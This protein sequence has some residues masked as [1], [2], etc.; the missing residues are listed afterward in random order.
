MSIQ[1]IRLSKARRRLNRRQ[2]RSGPSRRRAR[3]RRKGGGPRRHDRLR[4][5]SSGPKRRQDGYPRY[6]TALIVFVLILFKKLIRRIT[7][8]LQK[9]NTFMVRTLSWLRILERKL[10]S[11]F[12]IYPRSQVIIYSVIAVTLVC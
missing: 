4:R 2:S 10:W 8:I 9:Q 7:E 1:R 12:I 6:C 11:Q 5:R 3:R